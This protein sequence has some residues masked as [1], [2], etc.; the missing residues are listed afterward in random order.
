MVHNHSINE[1]SQ[2]LLH[3]LVQH[4]IKEGQLVGSSALSKELSL[5]PATIRNVMAELEERGYLKSPHTSAGRI[6][7]EKSYRLF[8]NN[9]IKASP[10]NY[11]DALHAIKQQFNPNQTS[12]ELIKSASHM[13]SNLTHLAGIVSAPKRPSSRLRH[14]EFLTLSNK[15]ILTVLVLNNREVHNRIIQVV[16]S[17]N[18]SE[19]QIAANFINTHFTG[20]ELITIRKNLL[21]DLTAKKGELNELMQSVVNLA[22]KS[23]AD[24]EKNNDYILSGESNLLDVTD[25]NEI[26]NL[27]SLL[28][29]FAQKKVIAHL[30]DRCL[31]AED[32]QIFI[33]KESGH[34]VFDDWSIVTAPYYTDGDI[35]GVLG[36]IGPQRMAY[37]KVISVVDVTAKLLTATLK[38]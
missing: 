13:M 5:S 17:F 15:R 23:F 38:E 1:R 6:P 34:T 37:D 36:V 26:E 2:H 7:T 14:I 29:A 9:L 30:F 31:D 4:Y 33:G 22:K 21:A 27:K 25:P 3:L 24:K 28:D 18:A 12:N 20:K 11:Q 32:V 10:T 35:L 16:R 8:V 19:L